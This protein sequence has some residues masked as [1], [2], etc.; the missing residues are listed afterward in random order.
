MK[1]EGFI[2]GMLVWI[3]NEGIVLAVQ[4]SSQPDQRL[5]LTNLQRYGKM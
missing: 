5:E 3:S 2:P 1:A 4:D